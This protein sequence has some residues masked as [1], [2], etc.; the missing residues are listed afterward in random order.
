MAS[1][2]RPRRDAQGAV[3]A[4]MTRRIRALAARLFHPRFEPLLYA[5]VAGLATLFVASLFYSS[6]RLQTLHDVYWT[7]PHAL[8]LMG[9]GRVLGPWS[10]PLDDVFI[11]FDFARSAARGAPFQWVVGNG[12]SSGGTSLLY[13][14]LL[15]PGYWL[16]F[17]DLALMEWAAWL[18]CVSTFALLLMARRLAR[19]LPTLSTYLLPLGFLCVG[20]LDWTLFSGMEVAVLLAVWGLSYLAYDELAR[21]PRSDGTL[22]AATEPLAGRRPLELVPLALANLLLVATRPE[23]AVLVLV[24]SV[25]LC[26]ARR[27]SGW[28]RSLT[29]ATLVALPAFAFVV[30]QAVVNRLLTGE[31]SAAGAIVKLEAQHPYLDRAQVFDAWLFHLKYQVLRVT[32]YHFTDQA[33]Y[34]WIAWIFAAL[35]LVFRRSRAS[36][37]VLL[38]SATLWVLTVAGNGQVRWQNERYTMPA[39]AWFLLA[40]TLGAQALFTRAFELRKRVRGPLFAAFGLGLGALF[41]YHQAPRFREQVWFFGRAARNIHDQ[42]V[43]TGRLLRQLSPQPKRVLVGDAGAI[44]YASDLPALDIIGLGGYRGMPF[45]RATRQHVGAAIELIERLTPAERPDVLAIYPGWWGDLPLWFGREFGRVPVRGN[46]I[47]GGASKVL[48]HA[49]WSPL[50]LSA[51]PFYAQ[52]ARTLDE[53]D[54]ADIV[55]ERA[56][57]YRIDGIGKSPGYVNMKVLLHPKSGRPLFDAGR[58]IPPGASESFELDGFEPGRPFRL[59]VRAAPTVETAFRVVVDGRGLGTLRLRPSDSWIEAELGPVS[60]ENTRAHVR[61]E[62]SNVERVTFHVFALQEP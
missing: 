32:Q 56:H 44:P 1:S 14:L 12:Y 17:R 27:S 11:H 53:L 2:P 8:E 48:Y 36:A 19:E 62:A 50:E 24:F 55:N 13:P 34:G 6:L 22:V 21:G 20:A 28:K 42:H 18:A 59:V 54:P 40:A 58:V 49:D 26:W 9:S 41:L 16:G 52:G 38:A 45:A 4:Q 61:F 46:V 5:L 29:A 10:A 33:A 43:R 31:T 47:C 7:D 57:G 51:A 60:V 35:G 15:V 39:V 3:S 23:A 37:L 25:G 30:G